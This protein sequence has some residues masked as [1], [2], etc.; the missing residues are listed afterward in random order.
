MMIVA[1]TETP[2]I[3]EA[4]PRPL[5]AGVFIDAAAAEIRLFAF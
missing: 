5:G 3:N 2:Q 1:A 4:Q